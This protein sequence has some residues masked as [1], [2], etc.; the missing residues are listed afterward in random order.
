MSEPKGMLTRRDVFSSWWRW[1]FFSHANYNWERYQATGFA[2]A[3]SPIIAKLYKNPDDIKAALKRHLI[4]F[5][6]EPDTGG[7]IHGMVIALEEQRAM[8]NTAIDDA[9]INNVKMGLM[10]PFAGLGDTLK[11]GVWFPVWQSIGIGIAL[12]ANGAASGI[13]GPLIYLI[14]VG[15]YTWGF[16]WWL[17]YQGYVQGQALVT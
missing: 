4:F 11:Q 13:L 6:A 15:F 16:G 10:G 5:N 7:V 3:M 1:L 8:G 2:H 17:Y 12:T 9:T 14:A